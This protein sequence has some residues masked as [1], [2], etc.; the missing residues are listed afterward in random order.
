MEPG[1]QLTHYTLASKVGQGGMGE[2]WR[3]TDTRLDREVAIKILPPAFVADE[4]RLRRFERE[5]KALATL[6]HPNVA[7]IFDID[8]VDDLCFLVLELVPGESLAERLQRGPLPLDEAL[9]VTRQIAEGLEAAHDAHVIHRDLKPANVRVTPEGLV[10]V[11]DFGLAK[12]GRT[13]PETGATLP[14]DSDSL[15]LTVEGRVL[16]TPTYMSPEQARGKLTDRRTDIWAFG[17]VLFELVSGRRP[18][19][20][21]TVTDVLGAIIHK[22]PEWDALP[23][24][25]PLRVRELLRR[26]LTKDPRQRLRDAGDARLELQELQ[27]DPERGVATASG[28]QATAARPRSPARAVLLILLGLLIGAGAAWFGAD[29]LTD[30]PREVRRLRLAEPGLE[31]S[32]LRYAVLSPDSR[33]VV[34]PRDGE[35]WLRRLDSFDATRITDTEGARFPCWSPDGSA[36][37]FAHEGSLWRVTPGGARRRICELPDEVGDSGGVIWLDDDTIAWSTGTR[38]M[39]VRA[40]AATGGEPRELFRPDRESYQDFHQLAALPG[41]RGLVAVAHGEG[42]PNANLIVVWEPGDDLPRTL[43]ENQGSFLNGP[44]ACSDDGLVLFS[45]FDVESDLMALRLSLDDLQPRGDPVVLLPAAACPSL[46]SDG[47]LLATFLETDRAKQLSWVSMEG[48]VLED[49]GAPIRIGTRWLLA[50]PDFTRV[51]LSTFEVGESALWLFDLAD[52]QRRRLSLTERGGDYASA[53]MPSGDEL[54]VARVALAESTTSLIAMAADGSGRE[55][56]LSDNGVAFGVSPDGSEVYFGSMPFG[57][58]HFRLPLSGAGEPE[59]ILPEL[60]A[61]GRPTLSPSSE[62]LAFTVDR[63]GRSELF[64]TRMPEG[65]G[66]WL[67][68][69]DDASDPVWSSTGDEVFFRSGD[70]LRSVS[71]DTRDGGVS[72]GTPRTHFDLRDANIRLGDGYA[73]DAENERLLVLRTPDLGDA[74][75]DLLLLEN[76]QAELDAER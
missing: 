7:Q 63:A 76:W 51:A 36:M 28:A 52:G 8:Q 24:H 50:S 39:P 9:D 72:I 73:V 71:V 32:W 10:K 20:G 57:A 5:A 15:E 42:E 37:A 69:E 38:D 23:T 41:G 11:L 6:N 21:E 48:R 16:G 54:L 30:A 25:T 56:H 18:F 55:R 4:E 43:V 26:C 35:L 31:L 14:L 17:C 2:V 34:F 13:D 64:L 27:A 19:T 61:S 45:S 66:R 70:E 12:A 53:W 67:L 46:S 33:H 44:L 75:A 40:V 29:E 59:L 22:E 58:K 60:V 47:S 49:V 65:E 74:E 1:K 68:S 3:A 62:W